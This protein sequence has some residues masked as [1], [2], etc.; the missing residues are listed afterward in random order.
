MNAHPSEPARQAVALGAM[1]LAVVFALVLGSHPQLAP[2]RRA[3]TADASWLREI[4]TGGDHIEPLQLARELLAAP[5][6]LVLVDLRPA[7]EYAAWHLPGAVSLTVPQVCGREGAALFA[8]AP[9]LVVLYSNGPAHPGQAWVELRRAGHTNVRVLAGGLADFHAEVLLPPSLRTGATAASSQ[10]EQ[11][12]HA[13][14]RA[15]FLG[16]PRPS[17]HAAWATD[18]DSLQQPT[19]VSPRW[20][21]DRL[22]RV[23]ILDVR[24]EAEFRALHLPGAQRLALGELRVP[25]GDRDLLLRPAGELAAAFGRLGIEPT[26]P[27]VLYGDAR[28]QDATL[29]AVALLRLGHQSLAILEGGIRRWATE[30]RPLTADVV[31][32]TARDY[33]PR[34]G[35]GN[36]VIGTDELAAEVLAGRIAPLDVRP[37]EEFRGERSTEA[38]PGHIPG[39]R[40]RPIAGD[41]QR[42]DDGLW[43]RPRAELAAAYAALG[44]PKDRPVVVGCRTGHSASATWFVLRHLLGYEHARWHNGSWTEWAERT[45]LPAATGDR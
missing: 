44:Y 18:P 40:N 11:P 26:T 35:A 32:P 20:L 33:A 22:G 30:R 9:R 8:R 24:Q 1:A 17:P 6:D 34:P 41:V 16:D 23:A 38:R 10:A 4:E 39:A 28:L 12:A 5:N 45:D 27:V 7:D 37:P 36:F 15:F 29:G 43:L 31:A 19:M 14:L 21:H 13:L 42:T 2:A 25:H 3:P